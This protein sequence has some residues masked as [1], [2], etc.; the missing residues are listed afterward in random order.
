MTSVIIQRTFINFF[1]Q[2][3]PICTN[4]PF[5]QQSLL[6]H[7]TFATIFNIKH[8]PFLLPQN[9]ELLRI[10]HPT[11]FEPD[12]CFKCIHLFPVVI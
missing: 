8:P 6:H 1:Q 9:S 7:F 11:V 3:L 10:P 5:N 4:L 12:Y 2:L